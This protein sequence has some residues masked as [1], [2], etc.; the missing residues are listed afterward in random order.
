M[1]NIYQNAAFEFLYPDNWRLDESRTEDG[2]TISLQ[3]PY[4]MFVFVNCYE[5]PLDEKP[6]DAQDV[7]DQALETMVQEYTELD[8][9]PV[10]ETIG[11]IPAVGHDVNFFSLDLTNTC[12]IRAFSAGDHTV[13]IFAQT[14]DLD[15]DQGEMAFRGICASLKLSTSGAL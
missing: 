2:L 8:S 10:S 14:N 13:L 12:W 7:A 15:L 9:E 6:L 1:N 4:S 5:K 11:D 3:S